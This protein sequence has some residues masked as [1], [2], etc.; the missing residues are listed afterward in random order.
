M[1]FLQCDRLRQIAVVISASFA[2]WAVMLTPSFAFE[3]DAQVRTL[4][5]D[6]KQ[7]RIVGIVDGD[8][9]IDDA[10]QQYR[11]TGIQAPKLPLGRK[12]FAPWP[13]AEQAKDALHTLV[14][15]KRVQLAYGGARMDRHGRT[16]AHLFLSD[17]T[18]VQGEMLRQGLARVYTF[19]DNR[20][21]AAE[22]LM[23]ETGARNANQGI[24]A[25]GFYRVRSVADVEKNAKPWRGTFQ[26]IEGRVVDVADVRGVFYLNFGEDWRTDFTV[27][28]PAKTARRWA[29]EKRD[30]RQWQGRVVR[31]RGWLGARNGPE[32]VIT[33][34]EQVELIV[35]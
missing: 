7:V 21:A 29:V 25:H 22:M 27:R 15:G 12:N 8:T 16:L 3:R 2:L 32:V 4:F 30:P 33:H 24:W 5:T 35:E 10:G 13:L 18:W 23:L 1:I 26:L 6:G 31:V 9:V 17:G 14:Q 19:A 11:L 34:P 28:I 20:T